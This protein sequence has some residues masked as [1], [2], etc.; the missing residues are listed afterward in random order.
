MPLACTRLIAQKFAEQLNV[1]YPHITSTAICLLI[2]TC[3][4]MNYSY[5]T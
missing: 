4:Q 1:R 2:T 3:Q 5:P